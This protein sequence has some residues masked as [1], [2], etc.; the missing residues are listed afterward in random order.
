M[1]RK[2]LIHIEVSRG[3]EY[4]AGLPAKVNIKTVCGHKPASDTYTTTTYPGAADCP[5]CLARF[6]KVIPPIG[7]CAECNAP[8]WYGDDDPC[9]ACYPDRPHRD[10]DGY[11]RCALLMSGASTTGWDAPGG[12]SHT[13]TYDGRL[14]PYLGNL[15]RG[16][17]VVDKRRAPWDARVDMSINGPMCK[18]NLPHGDI[19]ACPAPDPIMVGAMSGGFQML[20]A[21]KLAKPSW[22]GLDSVSLPEYL[23]M[24]A[25]IGAR[26]GIRVDDAIIWQDGEVTPIP[27]E[28]ARWAPHPLDAN[29][30]D[31][32]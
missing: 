4:P 15:V 24:W 32:R 10:H 21:V 11:R 5:R 6:R 22:R 3:Y 1:P 9:R 13:T 16:G 12:N 14:A 7:N 26:V 29:R 20:G 31:E 19:D 18:V 23:R 30:G 2:K 8:I 17:W 25:D 27:A 28:S